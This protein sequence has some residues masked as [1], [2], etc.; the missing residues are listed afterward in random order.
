[1]LYRVRPLNNRKRRVVQRFFGQGIGY[2]ARIL[3]SIKVEVNDATVC[4]F[5]LFANGKAGTRYV[6]CTAQC[7]N[8]SFGKGRLSPADIAPQLN[9]LVPSQKRGELLGERGGF[10]GA[11]RSSLPGHVGTHT[12]CSLSGVHLLLQAKA[13]ARAT[14][15]HHF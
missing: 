10:F 8:Q 11:L 6:V 12:A 3:Q 15:F 14:T 1:M 9:D 13:V 5:I 2:G 4:C 7:R